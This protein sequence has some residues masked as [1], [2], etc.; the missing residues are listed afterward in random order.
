MALET[1]PRITPGRVPQGRL[2]SC[3]G[4]FERRASQGTFV[5]LKGSFR[6][7]GQRSRGVVPRAVEESMKDPFVVLVREPT[8]IP[9]ASMALDND[10]LQD[11]LAWV[12]D[13]RPA[14]LPGSGSVSPGDLFP[15]DQTEVTE[16]D[17]TPY[18]RK[19]TDNELLVELAGR[20]CYH[21]YGLKA[22]RKTNRDYIAHSQ[23]GTVPHRSIMYHAKMTFF[24]AGISRRV[25]HEL[26]R[27][28]VGADRNEE[29]SPSQ[30]STRY[31]FHPGHFI[32]PPKVL[33]EGES[34]VGSFSAAMKGSYGGYLSYIEDE[35][36]RFAKN[37]GNLPKGLDRKRIYE[38]AAGFLPM[39]AATSMIWTTNPVALAK[40]FQERTDATADL[41]FNRFAR[42]WQQVC[43]GKWPNLFHGN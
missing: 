32:V 39:Q 34:A 38:A 11:L 21:S 43:C 15:H 22:G 1:T 23:S 25:S 5:K 40:L 18:T 8:V 13:Y 27:H 42:K 4:V 36:N 31:T 17:G 28:Y 26:I 35:E 2:G 14:C 20:N 37:N 33:E 10:G 30:E 7:Y 12:G 19:V 16:L 29:G 9:L 24:L 3:Q 6:V 41:E